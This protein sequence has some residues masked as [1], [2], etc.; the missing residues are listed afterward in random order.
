MYSGTP[1]TTTSA[2]ISSAMSSAC[3]ASA[4]G[5]TVRA[6][7]GPETRRASAASA[8]AR[9][10]SGSRCRS[11][12]MTE[13]SSPSERQ[14]SAK[15][16]RDGARARR[17]R[18]R[19]RSRGAGGGHAT[20][21]GVA[22]DSRRP[23]RDVGGSEQDGPT[24][25]DVLDRF[26]PATASGSAGRSP[27]RPTRRR[28]PGRRSRAVART[29]SSSRRPGRA[30]RWRRSSGRSTRWPRRPRPRPEEQRTRVLYISPL[31]ALG[32][33]V[34]RNLRSPLVGVTQTARR[35]GTEAPEITVGVRSGDTTTGRSP[36][37]RS[38]RRPTSSSR[39]PSRST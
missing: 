18:G 8:S 20:T 25:T 31:K 12:C 1:I 37:A 4:A 17:R 28:A 6:P 15:A 32:V 26:S 38:V 5:S 10:G 33:D 39:R 2:A 16:A 23:A 22:T 21:V 3:S 24:M 36:A 30:R 7:R 29:H 34:E 27:R 19:R 13:W 35:L 11:R 9:C 14:V